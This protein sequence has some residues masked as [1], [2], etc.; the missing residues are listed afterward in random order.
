MRNPGIPLLAHRE[1]VSFKEL[2]TRLSFTHIAELLAI[3]DL[4]KRAFYET[5][6]IRGNWA[7]RE[8]KR[9]IASLYFERS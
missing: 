7:V 4:L 9:Q 2:I 8:L 3:D 5:E 6:C 1:A